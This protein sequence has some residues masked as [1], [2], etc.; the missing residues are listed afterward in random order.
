M[1]PVNV[2]ERIEAILAVG[3]RE[4]P[5]ADPHLARC[6]GQFAERLAVALSKSARDERLYRQAHFDPL[7]ALPNRILFRDRLAQ[8]I[9]NA[10]AGLSRGALLYI[11]LD[12][13]K[14][15]NDSVGHSAGDQ[16][17]TIVAQRLRSCVKD[18][19]TVARLGGDEFTVI[20]RNVADPD[21]ARTVGER[22]IESLQLPV[23]IGGRD[24]FVCA[25]IGITL[26]PDDGSTIDDADAQRRYGDVSR[27]GSRPRLHDVLRSRHE[28]AA[29]R[30]PPTAACT[31]R[32]AA[33]SSRL[34]YQPQFAVAQRHARPASRRCCA[35]RRR[36][37]ACG[38]RASSC[39]RPRR[40]A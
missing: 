2:A 33:A 1:W 29:R 35:G 17:L 3:Y 34:F 27:Q 14:R 15:V 7:T 10:T 31:A 12:H 8:E 38:S 25:S 30:A 28:C 24:H 20:L 22:I 32:C 6:G 9:A 13:F 16:L 4:A 26:F 37:T 36:A 21:A 11:D 18:G 23:N 19:D 5:A 40:A 39:R